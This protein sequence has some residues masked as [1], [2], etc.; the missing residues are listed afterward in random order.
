[1]KITRMS[2]EGV[3]R[4]HLREA[5]RLVA[6]DDNGLAAGG[7][8]TIGWGTTKYPDGRR[9]QP[10]DTCTQAQA[11]A[12]FRVA[13]QRFERDVDAYTTDALTQRQFD[14]LTSLVY[15][16]GPG[17]YRTSTLLRLVNANPDNPAIRAQFMRWRYQDGVPVRGLWNRR[18]AEADQYFGVV[19]PLPEWPHP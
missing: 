17:N 19:T 5:C 15:N 1:M 11:D 8:W 13:L 6:Y 14:A 10:G 2:D 7:V 9:V 18:H 3:T 16:I 4:L 12:W